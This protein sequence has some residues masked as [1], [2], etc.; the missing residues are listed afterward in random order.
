MTDAQGRASFRWTP[1]LNPSNE[2]RLSV[3]AAPS[4]SL[5]I[6]AGKA[7]PV[8]TAVLNGASFEPGIAAGALITVKGQN[9]ASGAVSQ[10]GFP[11]PDTLAGVRV[12]L[13]GAALP[14]LYVSDTQINFYVP[15]TAAP[16]SATLS[17]VTPS[18]SIASIPVDV[19]AVQPGVFASGIVRA[20]TTASALTTPVHAGDYLE[21][22]CTGLGA[23]QF[24]G[25]IRPAV[26]P[27]TVFV[28]PFPV[29]PVYSGL[30]PGFL[31]LYQVN[32]RVPAGLTAGLQ[33]VVLQTNLQHSNIMEIT[34]Q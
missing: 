6:R 18:G 22:Y 30:A 23:T 14:L 11:W 19:L 1:G 28:G 4:V 17:V 20:G 34:V 27:V 32:V 25:D 13:N 24:S 7:V 8:V 12:T 2:L 26:L 3:G 15:Q 31:G 29:Q 9:F 16:G 33:P 5:S 10:S 21:I